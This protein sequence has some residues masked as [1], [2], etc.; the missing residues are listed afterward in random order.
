MSERE[1]G[2]NKAAGTWYIKGFAIKV[3]GGTSAVPRTG[4]RW[5]SGARFG[6]DTVS[7]DGSEE[8]HEPRESATSKGPTPYVR[9]EAHGVASEWSTHNAQSRPQR[10][11]LG[12]SG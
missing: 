5:H 10:A 11:H 4:P 8:R 1:R 6:P 3:E 7:S 9:G 2:R 12:S